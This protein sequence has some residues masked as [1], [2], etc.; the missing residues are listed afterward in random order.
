MVLYKYFDF[1][2]SVNSFVMSH[3]HATTVKDNFTK[4]L[5]EAQST[6]EACKAIENLIAG[7]EEAAIFLKIG[8]SRVTLPDAIKFYV[9]QIW[10]CIEIGTQCG[11]VAYQQLCNLLLTKFYALAS[12]CHE[13]MTVDDINHLVYTFTASNSTDMQCVT[14]Y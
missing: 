14:V 11:N 4:R 5:K 1:C 8:D 12:S 2:N 7:M 6:S 10:T 3:N 9:Q 13:Y